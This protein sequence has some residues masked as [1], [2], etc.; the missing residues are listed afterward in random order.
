[1]PPAVALLNYTSR[2]I[3]WRIFCQTGIFAGFSLH[4]INFAVRI[5]AAAMAGDIIFFSLAGPLGDYTW[6]HT[7]S[8]YTY[9][10]IFKSKPKDFLHFFIWLKK[11]GELEK[12]MDI[13]RPWQPEFGSEEK[14]FVCENFAG[15]SLYIVNFARRISEAAMG[16]AVAIYFLGCSVAHLVCSLAQRG[17]MALWMQHSS[18]A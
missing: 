1:M 5:S 2:G 11:I 13:I 16:G 4:I 6:A 12:K 18:V 17:S 10:C 15:F 8:I 14:P 3:L 9:E 7:V